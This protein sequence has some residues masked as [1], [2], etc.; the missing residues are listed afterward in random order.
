MIRMSGRV[1]AW[2]SAFIVSIA[3]AQTQPPEIARGVAWLTAQVQ[4]DGRLA[5]EDVSSLPEFYRKVW[6]LGQAGVEVPMTL[7]R[8]GLTFDVRVNSSDR[9]RFLRTPRLH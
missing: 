3:S 1:V 6:S 8:E 9:A 4:A 7:Y 5:G 2:V